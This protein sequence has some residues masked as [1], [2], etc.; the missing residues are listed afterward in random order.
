MTPQQGITAP[1]KPKPRG[2]H[3]RRARE[4]AML[5]LLEP[6]ALAYIEL[7]QDIE[8][9]VEG[10]PDSALAELL[11][12]AEFPTGTN[13]WWA[14]YRV[15]RLV[16]EAARHEQFTRNRLRFHGERP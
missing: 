9:Y 2:I 4:R 1:T 6:V 3:A 7:I 16:R 13:C 14:T 15:A 10:L 8:T 11:A 5:D 12:A